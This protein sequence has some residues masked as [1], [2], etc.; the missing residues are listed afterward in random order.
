MNALIYLKHRLILIALA[1]L[2]G[3]FFFMLAG[4]RHHGDTPRTTTVSP[5]SVTQ[6][7][8][9]MVKPTTSVPK[10]VKPV[11]KPKGCVVDKAT[12]PE[13]P[14]VEGSIQLWPKTVL[15][16][17]DKELAAHLK[18]ARPDGHPKFEQVR[19]YHLAGKI[20]LLRAI[21]LDHF[22]RTGKKRPLT[23][24]DGSDF[25]IPEEPLKAKALAL[26]LAGKAAAMLS[27]TRPHPKYA[28]WSEA[29][30]LAAQAYLLQRKPENAERYLE[31]IARTK[32]K[33]LAACYGRFLLGKLRFQSGKYHDAI[34]M[35]KKAS[36]LPPFY[37]KVRE[38]YLLAARIG[39]TSDQD[40][41]SAVEMIAPLAGNRE[42]YQA[43]V[44]VIAQRIL[45][46]ISPLN[47]LKAVAG[48]LQAPARKHL[49]A[50][51]HT[52]VKSS[53]LPQRDALAT[54]ICKLYK[55]I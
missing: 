38:W 39:A 3:L 29:L 20:L 31:I 49:V 15:A 4:R 7:P 30:Y 13:L 26:D 8:A 17:E 45:R 6:T 9:A 40:I 19:H 43:L 2:V 34:K 55:E 54:A 52:L 16:S 35:L 28:L 11:E 21:F 37:E 36:D 32:S 42:F 33:A 53:R 14:L 24:P 25:A 23:L 51:T 50:W 1:G 18:I 47:T 27:A 10:A 44:L 22:A 46:S 12:L 48:K 41:P 5:A